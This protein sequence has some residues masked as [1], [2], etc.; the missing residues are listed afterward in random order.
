MAAAFFRAGV[1]ALRA[2][3]RFDAEEM[4]DLALEGRR[5]RSLVAVV[6]RLRADIDE[7]ILGRESLLDKSG[8]LPNAHLICISRRVG[9]SLSVWGVL[10]PGVCPLYLSCWLA[11]GACVFGLGVAGWLGPSVPPVVGVPPVRISLLSGG[12]PLTLCVEG[13]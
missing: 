7:G 1:F 2:R 11:P 3:A 8:R 12:G 13:V 10:S 4:L 6:V 9:P 5:R